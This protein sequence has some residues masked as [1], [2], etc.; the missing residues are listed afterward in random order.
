[1]WLAGRSLYKPGSPRLIQV[2]TFSLRQRLKKG[3]WQ[4]AWA[5][6]ENII[7]YMTY[8]VRALLEKIIE[9]MTDNVRTLWEKTIEYVTGQ[10]M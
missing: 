2:V 9:Y 10:V 7:E 8:H 3:I 5:L 6:L 4:A 1:M